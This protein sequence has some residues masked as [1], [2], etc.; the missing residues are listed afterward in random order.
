MIDWRW[1]DRFLP[2]LSFFGLMI[3]HA[4]ADF[5]VYI[6]IFV[7]FFTAL[8][9]MCYCWFA[10]EIREF[11][12]FWISLIS[13]FASLIGGLDNE[14]TIQRTDRLFGPM[15]AAFSS[16]FLFLIRLFSFFVMEMSIA[17]T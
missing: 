16:L 1:M 9:H 6:G 10:T 15:W 14:E 5:I 13:L 7:I 11:R 8:A 3:Q 12:S 2:R 4:M 17:M